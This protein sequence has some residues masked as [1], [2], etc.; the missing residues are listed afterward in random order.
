MMKRLDP[1]SD[2]YAQVLKEFKRWSEDRNPHRPGMVGQT[3]THF[4]CKA[5]YAV[6]VFDHD[7]ERFTAI[8]VMVPAGGRVEW[9][10]GKLD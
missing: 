7:K 2:L 5:T 10:E 3:E 8:R 6:A 1:R 4:P 9:C